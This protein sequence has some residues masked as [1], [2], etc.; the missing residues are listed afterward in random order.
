MLKIEFAKVKNFKTF[1]I[2][3]A[4]YAG[5]TPLIFYGLCAFWVNILGD[6]G[7]PMKAYMSFPNV[8]SYIGWTAA[9]LN[10]LLGILVVVLVC[11][12]ITF[13]THR[14][15]IIDGMSRHSVILGKFY[16]L[17]ALALAVTV[18]ALILGFIFGAIYSDIGNM[19]NGIEY[20][21]VYF[22][23]TLGYFSFAFF[24][25]ILIRK[26]ALAIILYFVT[27]LL[28]LFLPLILGDIAVQYFPTYLISGLTPFPFL[29]G[30]LEFAASQDPNADT[31]PFILGQSWKMILAVV[32]IASFFT[33]GYLSL[34]KR[35]L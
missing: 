3:L 24:F 8:W 23:Q 34:K 6:F 18:Y 33:V 20:I 1:W 30:L 29:E 11:N 7:P 21:G 14:Q 15:N 10:I 19:F 17:V 28:N 4:C 16:F 9:W 2:I 13:K 35:D 27:F 32:Y 26:P 12:E 5:I 22:I 25:A 31:D